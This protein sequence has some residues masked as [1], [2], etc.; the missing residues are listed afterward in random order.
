MGLVGTA[1]TI[2]RSALLSYQSALQIVGNN[3]TNAGSADYTRQSLTLSARY[4]GTLPEGFQVGAGVALTALQRNIDEALESRLRSGLGDQG[5]AMVMKNAMNRV[6]AVLN[7]M[8]DNDLSTLIQKFFNSFSS[9]QNTPQDI[10]ARGV[11]MNQA[12]SLVDEIRRQRNDM[13]GMVDELNGSMVD[14]AQTASRISDEIAELNNQVIQAESAAPGAATALRDQRDAKIREL[15]KIVAITARPQPSGGI[16]VYIGNEPLVQDGISRGLTTTMEIG[17]DRVKRV[18][19]RFADHNGQIAVLGGQIEGLQSSRDQQVV[20]HLQN[21]D[22]LAQA[23]IFE[24]NKVHAQ[25]QGLEG[26]TGATSTYAVDDATAALNSTAAGLDFTPKTGS[27]Q[28]AVTNLATGTSKTTTI[29]VDLDGLNANDTTLTSLAAD[30]NAVAN[31]TVRV[32]ADGKLEMGADTGYDFTFAQ[33]TSNVLAS[34][35]I[36]TFFQGTA[37]DDMTVC[38]AL[39]ANPL[40]LAAAKSRLPGDGT[41]AADLAAVAYVASDLLGGSN[42][43]DYYNTVAG[44]IA[45]DGSAAKAANDAADNIMMS[46]QSQRESVSGVSLD[47][48]AIQLVKFERAF[49]GAARYVSVIDGLIDDMLAMV[50]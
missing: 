39:S 6:E 41:N 29:Y 23:L 3:I 9:L 8:S 12:G 11:V 10:T 38:T 31:M 20:G 42:V 35:G 13:L 46:L 33:D 22:S 2:G 16:N 19:V 32:R 47:E 49:Q 1:L 7:E 4:G 21:L 37:A 48:E 24:V 44:R 34:L 27:F 15:A 14:I 36:N 17:E 43:V 26:L 45:V 40:L 18:V 28:I 5:S 30:L 50:R 25:G